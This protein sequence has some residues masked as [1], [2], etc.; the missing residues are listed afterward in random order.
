M[1]AEDTG[2]QWRVTTAPGAELRARNT[3]TRTKNEVTKRTL[4]G[5]TKNKLENKKYESRTNLHGIEM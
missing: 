4:I 2:S 5:T 3:N 1:L